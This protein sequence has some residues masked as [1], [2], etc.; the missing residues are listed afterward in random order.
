[1]YE[2]G[3]ERGSSGSPILKEDNGSLRIVGLHR[4]GFNKKKDQMGY[5]YGSQFSEILKSLNDQDFC[6]SMW[7]SV[8]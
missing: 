8:Q 1:M 5:N 4:G 3:T 7:C 2:C 6:E